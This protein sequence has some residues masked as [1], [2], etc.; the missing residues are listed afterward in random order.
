MEPTIDPEFDIPDSPLP[1][2]E[3]PI[4]ELLGKRVTQMT[5]AELDAH[6]KSLR[7]ATESPQSLRKM[8][9]SKNHASKPKKKSGPKVDM[10][11]LGDL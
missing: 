6:V 8:L 10:S 5:D 3:C 9:L 1:P 2:D 11:L 7:Q 4:S